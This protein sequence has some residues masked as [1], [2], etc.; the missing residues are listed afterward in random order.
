MCEIETLRR[1]AGEMV[2]GGKENEVHIKGV[3]RIMCPKVG[4]DTH[5]ARD[6]SQGQCQDFNAFQRGAV[7]RNE[8]NI[9]GCVALRAVEAR[10]GC[11]QP[12]G[13]SPGSGL[14]ISVL[15]TALR[16]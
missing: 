1:N 10:E 7:L 2:Q 11:R 6:Q 3:H 16:S 15:K 4:G 8:A 14:R 5:V 9:V 12:P 13:F